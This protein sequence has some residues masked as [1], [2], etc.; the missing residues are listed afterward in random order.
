MSKYVLIA[1]AGGLLTALLHL[2]TETGNPAALI[3]A[4]FTLLPLFMV[5]LAKGLAAAAISGAVAV[6]VMGMAAKFTLAIMFALAYA[7]PAVGMVRMALLN[8]QMPGGPADWYPA[9]RMMSLLTGYGAAAL[10]AFAVIAGDSPAGMEGVFR[11]GIE[12]SLSGLAGGEDAAGPANIAAQVAPHFP[13]L[14]ITSWL[15]MVAINGSLAQKFLRRLGWN[16]RPSP[17][18]RAFE[19]PNWMAI[20]LAISVLAWL[21]GGQGELGFIGWNLML[22]FSVPYFFMGLA[23]IHTLSRPWSARTL[24]LAMFYLFLIVFHWPVAVIAALGLVEQWVGL[25]Q[26][27]GGMRG[28]QEEDQ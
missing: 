17:Q 14:I 13:A 19:L 25:R 9:G 15:I 10:I 6:V 27:I 28:N 18:I 3:F 2:S 11:E 24:A 8:R 20:A 1:I 22:V 16:L 21:V 5:G 26:R 4:Y 7:V 23:V 12:T